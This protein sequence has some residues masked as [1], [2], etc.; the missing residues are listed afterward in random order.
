MRASIFKGPGGANAAKA[1]K[2]V[3]PSS[4]LG[5]SFILCTRHTQMFQQTWRQGYFTLP[6]KQRRK[7]WQGSGDGGGVS[8]GCGTMVLLP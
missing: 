3:F 4:S 8:C 7:H 1:H 5:I 2:Q 6:N